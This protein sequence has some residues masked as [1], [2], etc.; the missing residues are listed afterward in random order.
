MPVTPYFA[1]VNFEASLGMKLDSRIDSAKA[2]CQSHNT[3]LR[4]FHISLKTRLIFL[5]SFV[6]SRLICACQNWFADL[7]MFKKVNSCY[8]MILRKMIRGMGL[9]EKI[10]KTMT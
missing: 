3:L 6:R 1:F 10:Q 8:K 2:A 9:I 4:K 7:T 5:N